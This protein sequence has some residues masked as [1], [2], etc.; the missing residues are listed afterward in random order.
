M[1]AEVSTELANSI[2]LDMDAR[3]MVGRNQ[4]VQGRYEPLRLGS[5][6]EMG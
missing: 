4:N 2:D 3:Y 6:G 5:M 1:A